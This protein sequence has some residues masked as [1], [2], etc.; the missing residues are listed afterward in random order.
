MSQIRTKL[1]DLLTSRAVG[2]IEVVFPSS[3]QR[4]PAE[5]S[6][7]TRC[8]SRPL[9]HAARR[10]EPG[11]ACNYSLI[12]DPRAWGP[13]TRPVGGDRCQE[14]LRVSHQERT[15][16][17]LLSQRKSMAAH[18]AGPVRGWRGSWP[19]LRCC[20][21][22]TCWPCPQGSRSITCRPFHVVTHVSG[23]GLPVVCAEAHDAPAPAHAPAAAHAHSPPPSPE[24]ET[25]PLYTTRRLLVPQVSLPPVGPP[26]L[27]VTRGSPRRAKP[28]DLTCLCR[29][30]RCQRGHL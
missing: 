24:R 21:C 4:G 27:R 23:R 12:G 2:R 6:L 11:E 18:P 28:T 19:P 1:L 3:R 14:H 5:R 26:A 9:T 10:E 8:Q 30:A 15:R 13:M 7:A 16:H 22:C 25:V 20:L 17:L 29:G